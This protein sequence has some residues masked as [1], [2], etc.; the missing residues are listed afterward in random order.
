MDISAELQVIAS[1]ELGND[2]RIAIASAAEKLSEDRTADISQELT[3]IQNGRYGADI[4]E[5]IY[6][7]LRK[8]AEST[9]EPSPSGSPQVGNAVGVTRGTMLTRVGIAEETEGT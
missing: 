9:P 4:R 3:I 5:A 6:D 1:A 2:V 7:A 8:L